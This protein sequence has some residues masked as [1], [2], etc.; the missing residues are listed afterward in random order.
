VAFDVVPGEKGMQAANVRDEAGNVFDRAPPPREEGGGF[1]PREPRA[2]GFS[3]G[4]RSG[5]G[6]RERRPRRER[7]SHDDM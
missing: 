2:G 7:P 5:D 4:P 1:T 3:R 6:D